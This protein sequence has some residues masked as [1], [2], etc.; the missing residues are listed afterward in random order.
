M[1]S[2]DERRGLRNSTCQ[3]YTSICDKTINHTIVLQCLYALRKIQKEGNWV[4]H[5]LSERTIDNQHNTCILLLE[6]KG[7]V[8]YNK[9]SIEVGKF[10]SD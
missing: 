9:F 7:R 6:G 8:F 5:Q 3:R 1:A 4:P 2:G 10:Y